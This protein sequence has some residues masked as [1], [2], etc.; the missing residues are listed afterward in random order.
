MEYV[1]IIESSNSGGS[2]YGGYT[3]IET[4]LGTSLSVTGE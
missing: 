2:N 3:V 1:R 4:R